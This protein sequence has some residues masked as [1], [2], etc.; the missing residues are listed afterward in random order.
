MIKKFFRHTLIGIASHIDIKNAD[1][2]EKCVPEHMPQVFMRVTAV[3]DWI[4]LN[5][6]GEKPAPKKSNCDD[7]YKD[8]C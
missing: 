5:M 2:G 7:I 8:S 3:M 6:K 1:A 4:I